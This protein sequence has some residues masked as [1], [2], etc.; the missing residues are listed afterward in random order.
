VYTVRGPFF[1]P[2]GA[3]FCNELI[4]D[5]T[6][7]YA[8]DAEGNQISKTRLSDNEQWTFTWDYRNRMTQAVEK[9]QAGV[10]VT[11][12]QFTYD[13]EDRRIGKSV[14]GTQSWYGYDLKDS[15]IDFNGSG[16][17]TM[18]YLMGLGLEINVDH[19]R[20]RPEMT[21]LPK[22][23]RKPPRHWKGDFLKGPVPWA[24]LKRAMALPGKALE[25]GL[26][27]WRE[28]GIQGR[29]TIALRPAPMRDCS[30]LPDAGRRAVRQLE[31]AGLIAAHR[32]AGRSLELTILLP[33]GQRNGSG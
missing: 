29:M 31:A 16:S 28:A 4:G 2:N 33:T 25:V 23:R 10:T 21:A 9:T 24:W 26:I 19:F 18:R 14:N 6:Y 5:G 20:L 15:Y 32:P 30:I 17:V 11:N 3:A 22:P 7:T 8:Y 27:L 13:A 1:W 12:D